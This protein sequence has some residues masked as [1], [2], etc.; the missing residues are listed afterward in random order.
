MSEAEGGTAAKPGD[1]RAVLGVFNVKAI[2]D[3]IAKKKKSATFEAEAKPVAAAKDQKPRPGGFVLEQQIDVKDKTTGSI[4]GTMVAF[5]APGGGHYETTTA[6]MK[7]AAAAGPQTTTDFLGEA[8]E[9]VPYRVI[10]PA[11]PALVYPD[12]AAAAAGAKGKGKP[13]SF[14]TTL[15]VSALTFVDPRYVANV[16]GSDK[17]KKTEVSGWMP[18]ANLA[19]K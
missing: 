6:S 7:A 1:T 12:A 5:W 9:K 18:L 10:S 17:D 15:D 19:P 16:T 4:H 11:T 2:N 14:D 13:V 3:A 8:K